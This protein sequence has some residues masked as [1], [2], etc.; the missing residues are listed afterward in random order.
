MLING[1]KFFGLPILANR[2]ESIIGRIKTPLI[3][4]DKGKVEVFLLNKPGKVLSPVDIRKCTKSFV[5]VADESS[6]ADSR[7]ITSLSKLSMKSA[8]LFN[9]RVVSMDKKYL[10]RVVDFTIETSTMH[11]NAITVFHSKFFIFKQITK[12]IP[13]KLINKITEKE[14]ILNID[15]SILDKTKPISEFTKQISPATS[16]V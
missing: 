8:I 2:S 9:K 10:G 11:L 13:A 6:F 16:G 3:N 5:Y 1:T 4:P 7:D 15:S 12:I 14:I